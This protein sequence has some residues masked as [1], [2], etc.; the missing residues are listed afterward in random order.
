MYIPRTNWFLLSIFI[1]VAGGVFTASLIS[2]SFRSVAYAP[3][4]ELILPPP[5]P[6][7][8]N[9][10]YSTEK[11]AWLKDAVQQYAAT[12][13][14]VDGR[15]VEIKLEA[16]GSWEIN[17]ALL[18]GSRKPDLISPAS[19]M[20]IA[21]L[22]DSSTSQFGHSLVTPTD[23]TS[24]RS[25]LKTPLVIVAW[26]ERA[27]ALWGNAQPGPQMWRDLHDALVNPQGW[28]AYGHADWGYIKFGHTDVL[29]S[30][31][32]F[33][34]IVL[35][36]YG[37]FDKTSGLTSND[38]LTNSD[39]QTWFLQTE[40]SIS[41]FENSTGPLMQKMITYGPS[42]YDMVTVY[43][44][45]ALEQADNAV[46]RYGNLRVYYPP[47]MLWSDHPFCLINADWVSPS[48]AAASRSFLDYL[49]SKPEQEAAL[50]YGFRP[51]D[52]TIPLNQ[53]NSPFVRYTANGFITDL[54]SLPTVEVPAGNVLN[55]LRDFWSRNVKR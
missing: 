10:L 19:S 29:T 15:P 17:S 48:Q 52:S 40:S 4:R 28:A 54:S 47:A 11:D 8:V 50:K 36:T 13:P 12:H 3:L 43:E 35:M 20:Q 38:I 7:T 6:V 2:P 22:Q 34:T 46:G 41:Q 49:T 45:T 30:N 23:Q 1:F 33:M 53:T 44:A 39:Y 27:N 51:V 25:V 42:T 21:A 5:K 31:S 26:Q 37:Y 9:L 55:T 14:M 16:M 24:C 18:D 32:G